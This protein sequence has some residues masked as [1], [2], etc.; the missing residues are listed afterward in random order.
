M[1]K[2][3][4]KCLTGLVI[5]PVAAAM[6]TGC[7][8]KAVVKAPYDKNAYGFTGREYSTEVIDKTTTFT[9]MTAPTTEGTV[10]SVTT[11]K[12]GTKEVVMSNVTNADYLAYQELVNPT[13]APTST[14][15]DYTLD[16]QLYDGQDTLGELKI[17]YT[18]GKDSH[19]EP[20]A[21]KAQNLAT[22]SA[23]Q[24][25]YTKFVLDAD[26]LYEDALAEIDYEALSETLADAMPGV[27]ITPEIINTYIEEELGI[28]K[29]AFN[30]SFEMAIKPNGDYSVAV[31]SE[32]NAM[33]MSMVLAYI[34]SNIY[35]TMSMTA[36]DPMSGQTETSN[37]YA[38][39]S[40]ESAGIEELEGMAEAA[41]AIKE[42]LAS[43]GNTYEELFAKYSSTGYEI[44]DGG[45]Y[46][47]EE[48][49]IPADPGVSGDTDSVVRYYFNS[50]DELIYAESDGERLEVLMSNNI[51]ARLFRT[52][53]PTGY[54]DM[55]EVFNSPLPA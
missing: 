54:L 8:D 49:I 23:T 13:T 15:S 43:A 44:I 3:L 37:M 11:K 39:I 32:T 31:Y 52:S 48:F 42:G 45:S 53:I 30:S 12:D 47:Y 22:N 35:L 25:L 41:A 20:T 50:N 10:S 27:E 16:F 36:E 55:S 18:G 40:T 4:K 19:E 17:T 7:G 51:P 24:G 38:K 14:G 2:S 21:F 6:L 9:G 5:L 33:E 29:G 1:K 26:S 46:Y 34:D 28:K